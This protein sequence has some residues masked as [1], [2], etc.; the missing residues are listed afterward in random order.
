MDIYNILHAVRTDRQPSVLATIIEVEGH[1]YRK[2][3]ASMLFRLAD[4]PIGSI[5]PG[6]LEADLKE[7]IAEVWTTGTPQRVFYNMNADED[8]IWGEAVGCG[9]RITVLLE[10]VQ[11]ELRE[12]LTCLHDKLAVGE[13]VMLERNFDEDHVGYSIQSASRITAVQ[14]YGCTVFRPQRRVLLFGA[15]EDSRPIYER[16][17]RV[18]FQVL[19]TDWRAGLLTESRFPGAALMA[20]SPEEI[21]LQAGIGKADYAVIT[22]HQLMYDRAMLAA[23][24]PIEPEYI[25]IIGSRRRIE[26]LFDGLGRGTPNAANIHAPIGLSIGAEGPEEIAISIAAELIAVRA[27]RGKTLLYGGGSHEDSGSVSGSRREQENG[28]AQ[29]VARVVAR[30][31]AR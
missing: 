22:S 14:Q 8:A 28:R 9:G 30:R 31:Y 12:K 21:V 2:S 10:A 24:L 13:S 6:C 7:R 3:G 19:V 29:T 4:E 23:L 26:M 11:G 15:G 16:L 18:G 27:G 20:G 5:S 1:S 25:G 17:R